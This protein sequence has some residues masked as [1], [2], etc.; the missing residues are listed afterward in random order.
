VTASSA[1]RELARLARGWPQTRGSRFQ[2]PVRYPDFNAL[3]ALP[4]WPAQDGAGR[5]MLACVALLLEDREGLAAVIDGALLRRYADLVG[6]DILAALADDVVPAAFSAPAAPA[7]LAARALDLL[8]AAVAGD[9][10]ACRRLGDA[11]RFLIERGLWP[12]I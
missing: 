2:R 8:D 7:V 12:S 9:G 5:R 4:R 10:P 11:E 6:E 1:R 3:A